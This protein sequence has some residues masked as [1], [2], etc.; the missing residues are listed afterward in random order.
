MPSKIAA[1]FPQEAMKLI[2]GEDVWLG[3]VGENGVRTGG[4]RDKLFLAERLRVDNDA[5]VLHAKS[6]N[7]TPEERAE[8]GK[9][10]NLRPFLRLAGLTREEIAIVER[11][12]AFGGNQ[13]G[14]LAKI[15]QPFTAFF[16]DAPT[17]DWEKAKKLL[18]T[19]EK[20]DL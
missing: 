14:T 12:Q 1:F 5:K 8:A 13:A 4:L 2:G 18:E 9:L 11:L 19:T 3:R 16:D 20:Y 7:A 15:Q 6:A 10:H 17:T